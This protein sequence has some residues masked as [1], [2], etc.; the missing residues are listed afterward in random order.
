MLNGT[1]T[2]RFTPTAP[3]GVGGCT[4]TPYDVVI[5][6][7][8]E[9]IGSNASVTVCSGN[10]LNYDLQGNINGNNAIPS[11]FTYTVVSSDPIG[12]PAEGN[13]TIPSN[14]PITYTYTNTT[15]VV[16]TVTY[17]I[18]PI[19]NPGGCAGSTFTYIVTLGAQPVL[20]PG[21]NKFACNNEPIGLILKETLASVPATDYD[22]IDITIPAGLTPNAGNV[23]NHSSSTFKNF[24]SNDI[25]T[26]STTGNLIV[27]YSIR[28][29][30]GLSCI[31]D[32]LDILVTVHPPILA[33]ALTGN[34]SICYNTDAPI[35]TNGA[36]AIR[37]RRSYNIQLVLY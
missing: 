24:L 21:L 15:G 23:P 12:V 30:V 19:S 16:V 13:R 8:P 37:R 27:T 17:T 31:G 34:T 33:G 4:G 11:Q 5:T 36:L 35:V 18:T 29:R 7:K 20:D 26:N 22:I 9:P 6:V 1:V 14:S 28:P 25:Y 3:A 32:P 10:A 2:Y